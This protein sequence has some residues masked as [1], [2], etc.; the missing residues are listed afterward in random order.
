MQVDTS[1]DAAQF[2]KA[3]QPAYAQY[4]KKYG[5]ANIDRIRNYKA[6]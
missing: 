5:Q 6:P 2:Q 1:V 3:L 4:A